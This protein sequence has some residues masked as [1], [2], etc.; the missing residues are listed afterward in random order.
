MVQSFKPW[1][2]SAKPLKQTKQT[3]QF[4]QFLKAIHSIQTKISKQT[5][6]SERFRPPATAALQMRQTKQTKQTNPFKRV[7]QTR[8]IRRSS[9]CPFH[10][11]RQ[12]NASRGGQPW[13]LAEK[14]CEGVGGHGMRLV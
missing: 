8:R 13:A 1:I 12:Q 11:T 7:N 9:G 10:V 3:K 2:E 5:T 14:T 4:N 6:Q